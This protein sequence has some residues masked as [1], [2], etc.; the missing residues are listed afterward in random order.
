[1]LVKLRNFILAILVILIAVG[2]FPDDRLTIESNFNTDSE[3]WGTD[4]D[5]LEAPWTGYS[6]TGG[7][8]DS[9]YIFA[10]D[11]ETGSYWYFTA[12]EKFRNNLS[13][14]AGGEMTFSMIQFSEFSNQLKSAPC[15][16][17]ESGG[18]GSISY[19]FNTIP[20]N[21]WT[22]YEISLKEGSWIDESGSTASDDKIY[23]VLYD[24]Q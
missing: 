13:N 6:A 2:C 17:I 10:T 7:V 1:M 4:G 21:T 5:A 14:Y 22:K 16:I 18:N 19:T 3:E 12:P 8:G 15:I 11:G 23:D 24:V 20:S 9:G